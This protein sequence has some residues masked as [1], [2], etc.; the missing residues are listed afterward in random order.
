MKKELLNHFITKMKTKIS[1]DIDSYY[2]NLIKKEKKQKNEII[3]FHEY[4][5]NYLCQLKN[6]KLESMNKI[7]GKAFGWE[8][9]KRVNESLSGWKFFPEPL[10]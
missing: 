7:E 6:K 8:I 1:N 4:K 9:E 2:L 10:I 3:D 5:F